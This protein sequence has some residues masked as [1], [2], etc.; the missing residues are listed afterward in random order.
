MFISKRISHSTVYGLLEIVFSHMPREYTLPLQWVRNENYVE[1]LMIM[2]YDDIIHE[3]IRTINV[4][5]PKFRR[6][7]L[8]V[9]DMLSGPTNPSTE[10]GSGFGQ[11]AVTRS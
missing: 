8:D 2:D 1:Q 7:A 3:I 9:A 5:Q 4:R 11:S 10:R 6:R